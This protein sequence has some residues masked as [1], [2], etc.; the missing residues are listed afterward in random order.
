M[1]PLESVIG[2]APALPA[3]RDPANVPVPVTPSAPPMVASFV[4]TSAVPALERVTT[5]EALTTPRVDVPV[6]PSVPPTDALPVTVAM[7]I[8]KLDAVAPLTKSLML[9]L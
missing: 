1:M 5:P 2:A 6:T 9:T 8:V 4:T 7:P 3:M